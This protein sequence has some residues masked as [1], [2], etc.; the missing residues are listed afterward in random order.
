MLLGISRGL[1][2]LGTLAAKSLRYAIKLL[3]G[4]EESSIHEDEKSNVSKPSQ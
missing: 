4:N 1:N 2:M 3:L